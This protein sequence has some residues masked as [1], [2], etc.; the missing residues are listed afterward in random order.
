[1]AL[2]RPRRKPQVFPKSHVPRR[3]FGFFLIVQKET[4]RPQAAK[5][6]QRYRNISGGPVRP[7][8]PVRGR[9]PEGAQGVGITGP[10][11]NAGA[12]TARPRAA[13]G[14]PY[15]NFG[16]LWSVGADLR[17]RPS[18]LGAHIGA[19]LRRRVKD[20]APY[21]GKGFGGDPKIP[22]S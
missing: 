3:F 13:K 4:R 20:A 21:R 16:P 19:P 12:R 11:E 9:C 10:Y 8:P 5:F 17:V 1:M 15:E 2:E 18:V 6:P 7:T 14:R 22:N